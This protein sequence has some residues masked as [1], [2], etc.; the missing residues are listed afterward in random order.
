MSS[1]SR[2]S[3]LTMSDF[4]LGDG[5]VRIPGFEG[6]RGF[7]S[8]N[9]E[10]GMVNPRHGLYTGVVGCTKVVFSSGFTAILV[11]GFIL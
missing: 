2:V 3:Q 5:K 4:L 7:G 1:L 6:F 10:F 8:G 9:Q 11:I